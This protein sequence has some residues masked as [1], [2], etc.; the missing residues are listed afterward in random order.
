MNKTIKKIVALGMG[1][2]MLAGTAAMALATDLSNYPAP[3]V[4]DG[5][6]VGKIVIG[7]KAAAIDTIGAM[8]IAAS[9][10]RSATVAVTTTGAA[11]TA[12]VADGYK[13]AESSDLVLGAN[14]YSVKA[15]VDDAN[16][17]ALLESGTVMAEDGTE[18]DYDLTLDFASGSTV[19]PSANVN[20]NNLDDT[21][22]EPV[23]F[24]DL[25][26]GAAQAAYTATVDFVD[27]WSLKSTSTSTDAI[28][29]DA[30]SIVLFGK[31]YTFDQN[32]EYDA[33]DLILYGADTTT[34]LKKGESTKITYKGKDYTVEVIGGNSAAES[35]NLLVNGA[36][37]SVTKGT[38][39]TIGGLP[40]Y[41]KDVFIDDTNNAAKE[42]SAQLFVGSNKLEIEFSATAG[43]VK[44]D[45]QV[46][47]E[48]T[49]ATSK[50]G[51]NN[52][53]NVNSIAFTVTPSA[54]S[55]EVEYLL[56]GKSYV[57]PVFGSFK[58]NFVGADD[59]A[60]G[61]EAVM[62]TQNGKKL[63]VTFTPKGGQETTVS[64]LEN[65]LTQDDLFVGAATL[66]NLVKNDIFFYNEFDGDADKA[67]THVLQISRVKDGDNQSS[68][69]YEVT[70]KDLTFDKEYTV[71]KCEVL[72]SKIALYPEATTSA[73]NV[74]FTTD[75]DCSGTDAD[76]KM[77]IY[78]NAGALVQFVNSTGSVLPSLNQLVVTSGS[79]IVTEDAQ[80]DKDTLAGTY[81]L[82]ATYTWN[83][84]D[85]NY[86]VTTTGV[87][88]QVGNDDNVDYYLSPFGTYVVAE[89]DN[90]GKYVKMYIPATEV[91]YD[92]F[93][94]PVASE[95]VVSTTT[96]TGAVSLNAISVGMAI[97]DTDATLGA[98]PYIVVGGPC[99]NTV[100]ASLMGNPANC[101]TGFTEGKAMIKLFSD[102][103]ALLVAGYSAKDTQGA[104]RVL[105]TYKDHGFSGTELEV[106]TTNLNS[107][108]VKKLSS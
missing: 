95:V 54:A 80:D 85:T 18:Y 11:S 96:S 6:F 94:M 88:T 24:L 50:T 45:G 61:K 76:N 91:H 64:L 99:A 103:N 104:C 92:A 72:T 38:S 66:N 87:G 37:K 51:A 81:V 60:K 8:D 20:L 75:S 46:L 55:D 100:S 53:Q 67:V 62:F 10:Q 12:S 3:F 33:T 78:T 93:L 82:N 26:N 79:I 2:T 34:T 106:A 101:V 43:E 68:T 74:T 32:V 71:T 73:D 89:T 90:P 29:S 102:K 16:L 1:A 63:D 36:A 40:I 23:V 98:T 9:L 5:V 22:T 42:V 86:R 44:L 31:T 13:F 28:N 83:T 47:D 48:V 15:V 56:P 30:A 84:A 105:A 57:D 39:T 21:N 35:V 70:V 25:G 7:E 27:D 65:N 52:W 59:L 97:L 49:A 4:K 17:P 77:N 41:I 108:T 19:V 107:L 58:L 69:S 14:L